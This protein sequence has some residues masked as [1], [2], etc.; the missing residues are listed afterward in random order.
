MRTLKIAYKQ[1]K[2][3][4]RQYKRIPN[5]NLAGEWFRK[6]GFEIGDNVCIEIIDNE[7]IIRK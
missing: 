4:E 3:A 7:M 1:V 6:A 2:N 5:L